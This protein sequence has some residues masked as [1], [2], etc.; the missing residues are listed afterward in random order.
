MEGL[1]LNICVE[2]WSMSRSV[3]CRKEHL[4]N[5][6]PPVLRKLGL[7]DE[8]MV[9]GI[10]FWVLRFCCEV[11]ICRTLSLLLVSRGIQGLV[12]LCQS[13]SGSTR[14][15]MHLSSGIL[16]FEVMF[17]YSGTKFVDHM[18]SY[19]ECSMY[20]ITDFSSMRFAT[21]YLYYEYIRFINFKF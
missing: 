15:V 8:L 12:R 11:L 9:Q 3:S 18:K 10:S 6:C 21:I 19:V 5:V 2:M 14:V 7:K 13:L 16:A 17:C 20:L 1:C 4:Q